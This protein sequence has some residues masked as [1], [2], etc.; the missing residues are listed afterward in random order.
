MTTTLTGPERRLVRSRDLPAARQARARVQA[1][2]E[3]PSAAF[4]GIAATVAVLV[5]LG[6]VM[7]LSASS[8]TSFH[9]GV[10]PWRYFTKQLTWAGLGTL[11][12]VIAYKTPLSVWRRLARIGYVLALLAMLLPFAPGIGREV[13]GARAWVQVGGF[14][15]Q[16]SEVL[17]L[18]VLL[19]CADL[20][21]RRE[22]SMSD[23]RMTFVPCVV[24]LATSAGL[25]VVQGDLGSAV[26]LAG[27]AFAV[28]FIGGVPFTPMG[29]AA[30]AFVA[31]GVAF[32]VSSSRRFARWTAFLDLEGNKEH[33]SYQVYQAIVSI[34]NGGP[35]GVGV[36]AG[37]G[38]WGYVPLAHSDFI[39]AIV[40]EE[41]GLVGAIAVIGG[42]ALLTYLGVHVAL[43]AGH[44]G[45]RF[46]ML[47]AGGIAAWFAVQTTINI[48][49]VT[50]VMPVTGLTLPFISFGG[51]S[52][53]VCLAGAGLL[54]NVARSAR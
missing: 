54:L 32:V 52:L 30:G 12:L 16:P 9:R 15:F 42:V 41:L 33:T 14:G 25:C 28:M 46:A 20:L 26:V 8:I 3:P 23:L 2:Q 45:D 13:E 17:K 24:A 50:G 7:V 4:Y 39:F 19:F 38:K 43:T 1:S 47:L 49:G 10:S 35:T 6:L 53:L 37:T 36:G 34:A 40:A 22:R 21:T 29:F 48:G 5:M 27:I 44:A 31:V 18:A 51:S 11:A